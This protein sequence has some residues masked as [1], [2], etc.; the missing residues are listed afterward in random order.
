MTKRISLTKAHYR[1][2][3]DKFGNPKTPIKIKTHFNKINR[4]PRKK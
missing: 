4:K 2:T 3:K 1:K